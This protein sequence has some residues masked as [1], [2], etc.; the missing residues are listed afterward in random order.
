VLVDGRPMRS[1]ITTVGECAG[2]AITTIE[3]LTQNGQLHPLQSAFLACDALQCG[4]C[5]PGM[6]LSGVALLK[7]KANPSDEEIVHAMNGNICRC[8]TYVRIVQAVRQA[9]GKGGA[10]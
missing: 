4:Y 9:A 10:Q 2:K 5:T 8:G 3:G 1:C 6:I 7:S